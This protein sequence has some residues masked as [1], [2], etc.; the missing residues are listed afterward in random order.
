MDKDLKDYKQKIYS[1]DTYSWVSNKANEQ[2]KPSRFNI[3]E[4]VVISQTLRNNSQYS[5]ISKLG[6]VFWKHR[7]IAPKIRRY[8]FSNSKNNI[9]LE[10]T[11][12]TK[13]EKQIGLSGG[14]F[15][16]LIKS[17]VKVKVLTSTSQRVLIDGKEYTFN[18]MN[19]FAKFL[20]VSR[21]SL[22]A[23]MKKFNSFT[24]K[25]YQI[26]KLTN[27]HILGYISYTDINPYRKMIDIRK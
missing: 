6:W 21:S 18:S 17:P 24:I 25:N 2:L 23:K 12:Q 20:K 27:K 8:R 4:R 1:K 11:N 22:T 10:S 9:H 3:S 15:N 13:L 14:T 19:Q 16:K 5:N 26:I 7:D